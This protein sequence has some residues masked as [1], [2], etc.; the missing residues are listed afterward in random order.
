MSLAGTSL[1]QT[2]LLIKNAIRNSAPNEKM[3]F[4]QREKNVAML[5]LILIIMLWSV[6]PVQLLSFISFDILSCCDAPIAPFLL[7]FA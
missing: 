7:L 5:S 2:L 3:Y 1:S 6:L 4:L